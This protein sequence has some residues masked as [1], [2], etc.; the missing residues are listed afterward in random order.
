[1]VAADIAV[2]A[3]GNARPTGG[4]GAVAMLVGPDA[5]LVLE[6]GNGKLCLP[7]YFVMHNISIGLRGVH[8]EHAYDF[9]KPDLSS[10]YPVV[11]G[12]LS[13]Q[14]YLGALDQCYQRYAD[15][16]GKADN[17]NFN[18]QA[19]DF[20]LFHSPFT[21]LVAKS[22]AR[23]KLNDLVRESS[24][25][26]S[27]D[28][29]FAGLEGLRGRSLESTLGDREVE[30]LLLKNTGILFKE[31]T[32]PSVL[33][34]IEVGNMYTASVYGA[35]ASLLAR[36]VWLHL[37]LW[38]VIILRFIFVHSK[39]ATDLSGKRVVLFSY[40]SGLA[41][42]MYSMRVSTDCS[43]KSSLAALVSNVRE[44]PSQLASRKVVTPAEFEEIMK[45]REKTHH[46]APY[47][48]QGNTADLFPATFYL[49][50]VD[51]KHR[52]T[53]SQVPRAEAK[54]ETVTNGIH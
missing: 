54:S 47:I 13:I 21:K 1:M 50:A 22:L 28:G 9:Y 20:L 14:C 48:P 40:G 31:K 49:T 23:L 30:K 45:L 17:S 53:Y 7:E 15:K 2:Y 51:E 18:L 10:E 52:R 29:E 4:A 24:P 8:M 12:K 6:S 36:Y 43:P 19:A 41:S 46:M 26:T 11:D 44:I 38:L 5:P 33:L 35:L 3:S 34:G 37:H 39:S 42:A 16:A 25:D 27:G 32:Q